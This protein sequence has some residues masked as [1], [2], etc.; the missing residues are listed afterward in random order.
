[1]SLRLS[2]TL[3]LLLIAGTV[4]AQSEPKKTRL[5]VPAELINARWVF[6]TS[7]TADGSDYLRRPDPADQAAIADVRKALREWAYYKEVASPD[8]ADLVIAICRKTNLLGARAGAGIDLST[9]GGVRVT[10]PR[11]IG[12]PAEDAISVFGGPHGSNGMVIWKRMKKGGLDAP[13]MQLVWE[14]RDVV[15]SGKP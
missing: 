3:T 5:D 13:K 4:L 8:A 12:G 2:V 1:M 6:L 10:Q 7:Y 14:F 11:G 15:E 9:T